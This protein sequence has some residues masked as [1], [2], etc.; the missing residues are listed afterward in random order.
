MDHK[1]YHLD[2][3]LPY[4]FCTNKGFQ[5]NY[6]HFFLPYDFIS[7]FCPKIAFFQSLVDIKRF[8]KWL[9]IDFG[10]TRDQ[11]DCYPGCIELI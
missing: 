1:P 5:K 6:L 2:P 11:V 3:P 9:D 8:S 7:N 10:G 4:N